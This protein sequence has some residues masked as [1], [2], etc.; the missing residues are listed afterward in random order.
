[1][2]TTKDPAT[3]SYMA[4]TCPRPVLLVGPQTDNGAHE[5]TGGAQLVVDRSPLI[6][7]PLNFRHA[8]PSRAPAWR[9]QKLTRVILIN[10]FPKLIK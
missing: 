7:S 5:L 6:K 9:D 2:C 4:L 10:E 1:M 3:W 8:A